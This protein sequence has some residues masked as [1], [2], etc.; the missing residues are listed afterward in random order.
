MKKLLS[1][2]L[3]I[4]LMSSYN[5]YAEDAQAELTTVSGMNR[6]S[7]LI[8]MDVKNR[9][10]ETLGEIKDLVIDLESGQMAYAVLETDVTGMEDKSLPIPPGALTQSTEEDTLILDVD[11]AKL[12]QA[13]SIDLKDLS[14]ESDMKWETQVNSFYAQGQ[15]ANLPQVNTASIAKASDL[16]GMDVKNQ[17]N[18]TVGEIND[19]VIDFRSGRISYVILSAGGFL[20]MGKKLL[21]MAPKTLAQVDSQKDTVV[22]DINKESI[23]EATS[24]D[25]DNLPIQANTNWVSENAGQEQSALQE[26]DQNTARKQGEEA[27]SSASNY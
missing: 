9:Q 22:L 19:L 21:P 4:L 17:E 8:G 13:P 2:C 20:G 24:L 15:R 6:A 5:T 10:N 26:S 18:E 1:L 25:E 7:D 23:K 12:K 16:I 11:Q 3:S 27:A 14:N